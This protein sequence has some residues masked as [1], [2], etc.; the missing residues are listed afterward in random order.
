MIYII[1]AVS[2]VLLLQCS[3]EQSNNGPSLS[4]FLCEPYNFFGFLFFWISWLIFSKHQ[5]FY[6]DVNQFT[7]F[8]T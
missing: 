3:P 1:I 8:T 7:E 4:A 2:T 5:M 6:I